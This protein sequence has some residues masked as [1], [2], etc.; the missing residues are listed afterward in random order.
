MQHKALS[1]TFA[2]LLVLG[3]QGEFKTYGEKIGEA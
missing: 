3:V 1:V 2:T